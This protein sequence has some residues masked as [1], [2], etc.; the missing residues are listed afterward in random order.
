MY[1][2]LTS[3]IVVVGLAGLVVGC[4]SSTSPSATVASLSVTGSAP[5]VGAAS[6]FKATATMSDGTTQDVTSLATW[7]SSNAADA[8]VS[9]TGIVTGTADG[10]DTISATYQGS[11]ASDSIVITG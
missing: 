5:T 11:T 10:A 3:L 1:R 2:S 8:S 7:L 9:T 4:N 6:Q